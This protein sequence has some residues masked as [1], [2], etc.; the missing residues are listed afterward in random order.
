M[1]CECGCGRL[2]ALARQTR[3]DRGHVAGQPLRFIYGHKRFPQG[4]DHPS[5]NYG[6]AKGKNGY[7]YVFG[8]DRSKTLWHRIVYQNYYLSGNDLPSKAVI[9]H[10]NGNTEDNR[11]ENLELLQCQGIHI[12][13]HLNK[14]VVLKKDNCVMKFGS[15][16]EA[17]QWLGRSKT[18]VSSAIH[19]RYRIRGWVPAHL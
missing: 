10:K 7:W 6:F 16:V 12:V 3:K 18:A 15:A 4:K 9:H 8:K 11:P 2:T 17:S 19:G 14:P 5:F 13:K 1:F